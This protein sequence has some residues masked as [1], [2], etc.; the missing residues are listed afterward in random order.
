VHRHE[1]LRRSRCSMKS[2][3][4]A[5]RRSSSQSTRRVS[6]TSSAAGSNPRP[7]SRR[8]RHGPGWQ[9]TSHHAKEQIARQWQAKTAGGLRILRRRPR[10]HGRAPPC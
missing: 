2:R 4:C 6:R 1:R 10:R 9:F 7:A 5:P 3:G 8:S